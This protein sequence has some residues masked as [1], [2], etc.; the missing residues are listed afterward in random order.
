MIRGITNVRNVFDLEWPIPVHVAA[1]KITR[2]VARARVKTLFGN[3]GKGLTL[4]E[5]VQVANV[6]STLDPPASRAEMLDQLDTQA[7][8]KRVAFPR[9]RGVRQGS[10]RI[11]HVSGRAL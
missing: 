4:A 10:A 7:S 2:R 1:G 3:R 8:K 9:R 6:C 5:K 11:V